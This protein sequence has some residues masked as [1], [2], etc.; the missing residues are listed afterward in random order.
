MKVHAGL[1][2]RVVPKNKDLAAFKEAGRAKEAAASKERRAERSQRAPVKE[3]VTVLTLPSKLKSSI[4]K[5]EDK[6]ASNG[7]PKYRTRKGW[8]LP[9][10]Y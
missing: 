1:E 6:S 5:F 8:N 10:L 7:L 3:Q 9:V 4:C 2:Y